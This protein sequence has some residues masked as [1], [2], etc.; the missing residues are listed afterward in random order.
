[1]L[2]I[3]HPTFG[4]LRILPPAVALWWRSTTGFGLTS[5]FGKMKMM[6]GLITSPDDAPSLR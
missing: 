1:M 2:I 3:T 6:E 4:H 5:V